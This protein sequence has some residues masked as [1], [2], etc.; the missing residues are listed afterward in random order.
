MPDVRLAAI[1]I[2]ALIATSSVTRAAPTTKPGNAI[3]SKS[4]AAIDGAARAL[5]REWAAGKTKQRKSCN[6]FQEHP[7]EDVTSEAIFGALERTARDDS[8]QM[9]YVRWQLLSG[10]NGDIAPELAARATALYKAFGALK[11]Q[12]GMEQASRSELEMRRRGCQENGVPELNKYIADEQ[13][14]VNDGNAPQVAFRDE[15]FSR[16]PPTYDTIAA[17]FEDAQNRLKAGVPTK[18]HVEKVAAITQ[19]WASQGTEQQL[20]A[21]ADALRTL[22]KER[23]TQYYDSA[24]WSESTRKVTF[25]KKSP[26][27]DKKTLETLAEQLSEQ[28]S[29]PTPGG[30]KFKDEKDKKKERS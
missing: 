14:K 24:S 2:F 19:Q 5:A 20:S 9:A 15:L 7:S 12:P 21:L 30:L 8:P 4:M 18:D 13:E 17:G 29:H 1:L 22:S 11:K 26:T 3:N 10:I 16:L 6:Y 28:A 25:Y 27:L 23:G